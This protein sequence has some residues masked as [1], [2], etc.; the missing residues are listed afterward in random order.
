MTANPVNRP[1]LVIFLALLLLLSAT[2]VR[3]QEE[4]EASYE[5]ED[6]GKLGKIYFEVGTWISQPAGLEY[7]PA[8]ISLTSD[9]FDTELI[10]ME[11]GTETRLRYRGGY[12]LR[13]NLGAIMLTWYSHEH[14]VNQRD[15]RPG[16]YVFGE[17]MAHPLYA[18]L[19][20]DGRADGY[21]ANA[22]TVLRD[23]RIDFERTAF[24][25]PRAVGTWFVGYRRIQHKRYFDV[26]Y[27]SILNTIPPL[28]PPGPDP[29]PDLYPGT[30]TVTMDSLLT[31][32]GFEGGMDFLIPVYKNDL[33]V[34]AGFLV[35]VLRGDLETTYRS[36][37]QYYQLSAPP[38][39]P[40]VLEPPYNFTTTADDVTQE[41]SQVGLKT[42][43]RQT[44]SDITEVYLGMRWHAWRGLDVFGGFRQARYNDV[45]ADLRPK[46][47][48]T[49]AGTNIQDVSEVDRSVTYEGFY[50]GV[51][52]LF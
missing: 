52:Y 13:S 29:R 21:E 43:G 38:E 14:E 5:E 30:D 19:N 36:T 25:S 44:S 39:P 17:I 42:S 32:R 35:A 3:A 10:R 22:R 8:T 7:E 48:T 16:Q 1:A 31:S 28:I 46:N 18:G 26:E 2:S 12:K 23:F 40:V 24:R 20:N 6:D 41:Q 34:E 47:V 37:T 49:D 45:G 50:V 4:G 27:Y 11:Q 33:L 15:T 51:S 9:P